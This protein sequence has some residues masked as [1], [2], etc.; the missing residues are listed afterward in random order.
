MQET[1][2]TTEETP[3]L[4]MQAFKKHLGE[5]N[6]ETPTIGWK[7]MKALKRARYDKVVES[8]DDVYVLEN[9]RTGIVVEIQGASSHHACK[10][11]GWRPKHT[12]LLEVK[13]VSLEKEDEEVSLNVEEV[14]NV[15][16]EQLVDTN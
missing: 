14:N 1:T 11:I 2:Q 8:F 12:K 15:K 3:E 7:E 16:E 10:T 6:N 9:K 13:K 4:D 5:V